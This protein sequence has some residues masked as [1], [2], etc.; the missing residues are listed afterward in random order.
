MKFGVFMFPT[1]YSID[2]VDLGRA[3]EERGFESLFFPEHTHIPTS[4]RSPFPRGGDLPMEYSHT[5][6]PFVALGAVAAVTK[7]LKLATGICLVIERDPITLAKEVASLDFIS[8]GRFLFGVGG[9]WNREEMENHGTDPTVRWKVL[10][11]RI[12]AMKAIWQEDEAEYHG[13]YVNFDKI[14]Q[15]PKPVQKPYPPILV[16]GDA[17]NTLKRVV[18]YGDGWLPNSGRSP[19]SLAR[20]L[21]ELSTLAAEAGRGPIPTSLFG[22]APDIDRGVLASYQELGVERVIYK[23][24][25]APADQ[26]LPLMDQMAKMKESFG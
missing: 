9:G 6:D 3:A 2:P 4:R 25:P 24:P 12:A 15:W 19:T 22:I 18:A 21:D 13:E 1:D 11:E 5:Y 16:G 23:L 8:G 17:P 20:K 10:R 14:W 7:N 26:V